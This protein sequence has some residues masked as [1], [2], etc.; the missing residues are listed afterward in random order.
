MQNVPSGIWYLT[1]HL[2]HRMWSCC[3]CMLSTVLMHA[4]TGGC[5]FIDCLIFISGCAFYNIHR[6]Y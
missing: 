3:Y 1:Y 4:C 5:A 6:Q 2:I